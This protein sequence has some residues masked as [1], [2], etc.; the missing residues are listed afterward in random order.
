[1]PVVDQVFDQVSPDRQ[2]PSVGRMQDICAHLIALHHI[3]SHR[4]ASRRTAPGQLILRSDDMYHHSAML[5]DCA[6]R[7]FD[8]ITHHQDIIREPKLKPSRNYTSSR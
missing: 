4:I 6:K 1:M 8:L 7:T 3:S 5:L 2:G